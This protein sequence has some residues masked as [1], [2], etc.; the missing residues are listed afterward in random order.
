MATQ[1]LVLLKIVGES[2]RVVAERCRAWVARQSA[3]PDD[4]DLKNE[5]GRFAEVLDAQR[6][7]LPVVYY[8]GWLDRW[9]TGQDFS[10][11]FTERGGVALV[12]AGRF[13]DI[14]ATDRP[15]D[16]LTLPVQGWQFAEQTLLASRLREAATEWDSLVSEGALVLLRQVVGASTGDDEIT[17]AATIVPGWLKTNTPP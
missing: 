6:T 10:T 2:G 9:S 5:I 4:L 13:T 8:S 17:T 7:E 12:S 16:M 11:P 14:Y 15:A 3:A 1:R